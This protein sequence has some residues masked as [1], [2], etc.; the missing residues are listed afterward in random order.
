VGGLGCGALVFGKTRIAKGDDAV[1]GR[2]LIW[3]NTVRKYSFK[4]KG[5]PYS[6]GRAIRNFEETGISMD[7]IV[8]RFKIAI[9]P[10]VERHRR[11]SQV[12]IWQLMHEVE[13]EGVETIK[14]AG[15][16]DPGGVQGKQGGVATQ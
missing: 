12:L 9:I 2:N 10:M 11:A 15:D 6:K 8:D 1:H 5:I 4:Y 16:L 14:K 3:K 13:Y 7:A